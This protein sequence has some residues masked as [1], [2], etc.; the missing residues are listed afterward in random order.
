MSKR[1]KTVGGLFL[2]VVYCLAI[3]AVNHVPVSPDALSQI[4]NQKE[5]FSNVKAALHDHASPSESTVKAQATSTAP[6]FNPFF[7]GLWLSVRASELLF[8]SECSQYKILSRNFLVRIRKAD[9]IFPFH[10][11]W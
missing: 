1:V 4:G 10:Y 11:F 2:I 3:S 6:G 7:T 8:E 9:L 5:Y